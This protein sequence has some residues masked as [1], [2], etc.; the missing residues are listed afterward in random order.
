[1]K[2]ATVFV[3]GIITLEVFMVV[4]S[5][6]VAVGLQETES[7]VLSIAAI[8]GGIGVILAACHR[9]WGWG[10]KAAHVGD[11]VLGL[12]ERVER[13]EARQDV[14]ADRLARIEDRLQIHVPGTH[15]RAT[16]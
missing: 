11:V 5:A 7:T 6:L 4:Q 1:M 12:D 14:A 15:R 16:D 3:G 10:R 2:A 8:V 9:L 13:I